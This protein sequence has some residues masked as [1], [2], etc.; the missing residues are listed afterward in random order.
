MKSP[1]WFAS[2]FLML[3]LE[4]SILFLSPVAYG[5]TPPLCTATNLPAGVSAWL[6]GPG[7]AVTVID[8]SSSSAVCQIN[9]P[10]P[11]PPPPPALNPNTGL[12]IASPVTFT[13]DGKY[14][15]VINE[16][17]GSLWKIST[18]DGS[19]VFS[20]KS[21]FYDPIGVTVT[22][23][24]L[25]P[26][27]DQLY[28]ASN[29]L[30]WN[31]SDNATSVLA[32]TA[33]G[34]TFIG[35][36]K[37]DSL[38][39]TGITSSKVDGHVY[40]STP[41]T[42]FQITPL[43]APATPVIDSGTPIKY[44][45]SANVT[46][47]A[48]V[49]S[50]DGATIYFLGAD[51]I[52]P[53]DV[54][55]HTP[56]SPIAQGSTGSNF[57]S[58]AITPDGATLYI[59][60][61]GLGLL[62]VYDISTGKFGSSIS[63]PQKQAYSYLSVSPDNSVAYILS[64]P[65]GVPGSVSTSFLTFVNPATQAATGTLNQSSTPSLYGFAV[66]GL[67]GTLAVSTTTLPGGQIN[68]AYTTTLAATGGTPPYSWAISSGNLPAGLALNDS[69]GI[70]SGTPTAAGITN[71]TVQVTDSKNLSA[72]ANLSIT[73][74]G[75]PAT[76]IVL[77][78]P[79]T[80][81][82]GT[83]LS[84]CAQDANGNP[85]PVTWSVSSGPGQITNTANVCPL[86]NQTT[87]GPGASYQ[88][89]PSPPSGSTS[90]SVVVTAT[91]L[92]GSCPN[93]K[94]NCSVP[95]TLTGTNSLSACCSLPLQLTTT[96]GSTSNPTGV[97]LKGI[98]NTSTVPFTLSCNTLDTQGN[99]QPMP[100]GSGCIFNLPPAKGGGPL[101]VFSAISG[102]SPVAACYVFTTGPTTTTAGMAIPSSPA[103]PQSA[104][105]LRYSLVTLIIGICAAFFGL[106]KQK[107]QRRLWHA[108][109][110]VLGLVCISAGMLGGCTG[111]SPASVPLPAGQVTPATT[112]R[113]LIL[114]TPAP[115]SGFTQSQL[116]VPFTVN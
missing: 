78:Q 3:A 62:H 28:V 98:S 20:F 69:T 81:A 24:A 108:T 77:P 18:A 59:G 43:A 30:L 14:A 103:W 9:I 91:P 53:F 115:G 89:P 49:A 99:M 42:L 100:P 70:I 96:A 68:T 26:G 34:S 25:S 105:R 41:T 116:I 92:S 71:F 63:L 1:L 114:A 5:Q 58:L 52:T 74:S 72:T 106:S 32:L 7:T 48:L 33:D 39:A 37:L 21:G 95:F 35:H 67:A 109:T 79:K 19:T 97:Q 93:S 15:Y 8:V 56:L 11:P 23:L 40:V 57:T 75:N 88:A 76:L 112:Y 22:G 12:A 17:F 55:S 6:S 61:A 110:A 51:R 27:Q 31:N 86:P 84:F 85:V 90:Q 73:V 83:S 46:G 104:S 113:V 36:F 2:Y 111:F 64:Q 87:L 107:P 94:T 66:T 10:S 45:A 102:T 82:Y 50:P 54:A 29:D 80:V 16:N 38:N 44:T 65:T 60:D 101:P 13:T 4:V 47:Q